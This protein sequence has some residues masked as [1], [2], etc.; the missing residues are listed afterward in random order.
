[1]K[2]RLLFLVVLLTASVLLI[3]GCADTVNVQE[4][5]NA[6]PSGLFS[7]FWHGLISPF[8][9]IGSLFSDN[10]AVYSCNNTGGWYDFGF[11]WGAGVLFGGGI[12]LM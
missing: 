8:S 10:I 6:S 11:L 4:C 1:M 3:T 2:K 5:V 7:G 9:F 12:K